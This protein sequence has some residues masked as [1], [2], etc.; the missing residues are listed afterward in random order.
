M[1]PATK[2]IVRVGMISPPLWY[3]KEDRQPDNAPECGVQTLPPK[4]ANH[5]RRQVRTTVNVPDGKANIGE[6]R[7][8]VEIEIEQVDNAD[9]CCQREHIPTIDGNE[10]SEGMRKTFN[11]AWKAAWILG[12]SPLHESDRKRDNDPERN[13]TQNVPVQSVK[14]DSPKQI[15]AA[16]SDFRVPDGKT[17]AGDDA[18]GFLISINVPAD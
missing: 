7:L 2:L 18:N 17:P 9:A 14:L 10:N 16:R 6:R 1:I 4:G 13:P 3:A 15:R 12:T 5:S 8:H 11:P